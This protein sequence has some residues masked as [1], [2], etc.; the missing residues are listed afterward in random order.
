MCSLWLACLWLHIGWTSALAAGNA[1]IISP[2]ASGF[3]QM[4]VVDEIEGAVLAWRPWDITWSPLRA[5]DLI[6]DR[7][8]IQSLSSAKIFLHRYTIVNQDE[9]GALMLAMSGPTML[10]LHPQIMRKVVLS[11]F[12]MDSPPPSASDKLKEKKFPPSVPLIQAWHRARGVGAVVTDLKNTLAPMLEPKTSNKSLVAAGDAA[13][14]NITIPKD[15]SILAIDHAPAEIA[16]D[17]QA[18]HGADSGG[19][20]LVY[21]WPLSGERDQPIAESSRAPVPITI[22]AGGGFYLMVTSRDG[23]VASD[24][25][26]INVEELLPESAVKKIG[27]HQ[28]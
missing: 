5:G 7:A 9:D 3:D 26:L 28:L 24:R 12:T 4:F 15:G 21:L 6:A 11:S 2:P 1:A 22:P 25:I 14:I 19:G 17:W 27:H 10:R 18:S 13:I 23:M 20:F 16:I 8:L